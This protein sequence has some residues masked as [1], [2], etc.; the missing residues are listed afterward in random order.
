MEGGREREG[1]REGERGPLTGLLCVLPLPLVPDSG[2]QLLLLLPDD[3]IGQQCHKLRLR[4]V[5]LLPRHHVL[6]RILALPLA[7]L[8]ILALPRRHVHDLALVGGREGGRE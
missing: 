6:H 3:L 7:L 8:A 5:C 2:L 1:G 4:C